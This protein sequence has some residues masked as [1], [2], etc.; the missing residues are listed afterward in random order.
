[1]NELPDAMNSPE[2]IA[3]DISAIESI[4]ACATRFEKGQ[5]LSA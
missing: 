5:T 1:M 4:S 3:R 2:A